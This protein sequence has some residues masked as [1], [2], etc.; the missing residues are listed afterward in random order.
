MLSL[1]D[2]GNQFLTLKPFQMSAG[3]RRADV[4]DDCEFRAGTCAT[5][6]Q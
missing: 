5:I 4:G 1:G 2:A 3:G 6:E